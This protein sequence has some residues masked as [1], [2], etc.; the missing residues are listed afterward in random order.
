MPRAIIHIQNEKKLTLI[1]IFGSADVGIL[2]SVVV[3]WS[4]QYYELD[5]LLTQNTTVY[6]VMV[7]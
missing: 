5:P 1:I 2:N 6:M 4:L 3:V 7:V